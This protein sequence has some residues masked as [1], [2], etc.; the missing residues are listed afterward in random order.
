MVCQARWL[1]PPGGHCVSC[2]FLG[3][4]PSFPRLSRPSGC[5]PQTQPFAL[6]RPLPPL[7]T[8]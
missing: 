6:P 3:L 7:P 2:S 8:L 1:L 4:T 5:D